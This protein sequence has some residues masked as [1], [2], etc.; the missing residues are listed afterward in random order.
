M[1]CYGPAQC[2]FLVMPLHKCGF[3][4]LGSKAVWVGHTAKLKGIPDSN[5]VWL[6]AHKLA[7]ALTRVP[8]L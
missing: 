5:G 8:D 3:L 6:K 2:N 1:G 4:D 7:H